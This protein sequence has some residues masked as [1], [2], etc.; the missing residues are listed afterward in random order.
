VTGVRGS[1]QCP[2]SKGRGNGTFEPDV[3]LAQPLLVQELLPNKS[4]NGLQTG[5]H[6]QR[7]PQIFV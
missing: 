3:R 6:L 4:A 2:E 7:L 1:P 5:G